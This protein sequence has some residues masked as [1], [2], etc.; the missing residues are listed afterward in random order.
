MR[1]R[2]VGA[3]GVA[4]GEMRQTR[5]LCGSAAQSSADSHRRL[6]IWI[7]PRFSTSKLSLERKSCGFKR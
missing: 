1:V 4:S 5:G 3:M 2:G 7:R 6:F